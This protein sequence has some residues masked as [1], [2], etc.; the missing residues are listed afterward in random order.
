MF[1]KVICLFYS[2]GYCKFKDH[3]HKEH[4]KED[5]CNSSFQNKG[6]LKD[7]RNNVNIK[8]FAEDTKKIKA[9]NSCIF[10]LLKVLKI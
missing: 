10:T 6:V 1:E 2:V 9:V 3:C 5:C 7:I 4:P 8:T